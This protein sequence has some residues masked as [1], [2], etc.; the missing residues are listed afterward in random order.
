M[1][2][3]TFHTDASVAP[4]LKIEQSTS[5]GYTGLSYRTSLSQDHCVVFD[6][7]QEADHAFWMKHVFFPIDIIFVNSNYEVVGTVEH[8]EPL[9]SNPLTVGEPSCLVF[10]T[11]AGWANQHNIKPGTKISIE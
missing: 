4:R 11:N 6:F 9:T 1:Y 10:E 3:V 5:L 8:A 2:T 7:A